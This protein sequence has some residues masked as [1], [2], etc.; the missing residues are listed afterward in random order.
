MLRDAAA[1]RHTGTHRT[2]HQAV[3]GPAD[4][5]ADVLLDLSGLDG[6]LDHQAGDLIV[7]AQA[8]T[9]L[10]DVQDAVGREG[11]R[12]ALDETVPGGH[13]RRHRG[14]QRLGPDRGC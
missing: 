10:S 9:R 12:L 4:D 8:G 14:D 1:H 6:V 7:E 2:R 3:L 11:Q 5:A 13:H